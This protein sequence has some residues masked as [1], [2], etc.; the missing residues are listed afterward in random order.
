MSQ[1]KSA[2]VH[3]TRVS[4]VC[5]LSYLV[6]V[7]FHNVLVRVLWISRATSNVGN[8]RSVP[9]DAGEINKELEVVESTEVG[10]L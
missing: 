4:H 1:A 6:F 3:R 10:D 2:L 9:A 5:V 8:S 7:L